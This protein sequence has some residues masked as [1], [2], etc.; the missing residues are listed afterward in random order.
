MT[1]IPTQIMQDEKKKLFAECRTLIREA[2]A[3]SLPPSPPSSP[4]STNAAPPGE[5]SAPQVKD[6]PKPPNPLIHPPPPASQKRA[7]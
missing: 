2:V 4:Q 7:S 5:A 6:A 1:I 3:Q